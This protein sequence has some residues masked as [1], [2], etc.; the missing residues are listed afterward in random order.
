MIRFYPDTHTYESIS[1]ERSLNWVSVTN[2]VSQF[3]ESFDAEIMAARCSKSKKSKWFGMTPEEIIAVW[4]GEADRAVT[5]GTFYHEERET[6]IISCTTIEREGRALPVFK[7]IV[8]NGIKVAPNQI[9][10]EGI[11]PEHMVFLESSAICGQSDKVEIIDTYIDI[12]DYKTNKEIKRE[13]YR[14][15]RGVS[16]KMLGPLNHLDD[17]NFVHYALQL[18]IY[19]Y[20]IQRHNPRLKVRSLKIHHIVFEE[21]AQNV[22]GYPI[23]RIDSYKNPIVKTVEPIEVPYYKNEVVWMLNWLDKNR[24]NLRKKS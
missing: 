11:Y 5:L 2:L 13:G 21:I 1:P 8:E 20:I 19:A 22:Y 23:T 16:K 12:D 3:K 6:E 15:W 4:N 17:C 24:N 14:D 18:S 9:L 10:Q 7:P